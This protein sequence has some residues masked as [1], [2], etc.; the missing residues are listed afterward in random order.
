MNKFNFPSLQLKVLLCL[1]LSSHSLP[2]ALT[3]APVT[4][5]YASSLPKTLDSYTPGPK[6]LLH[7]LASSS[8]SAFFS[9]HHCSPLNL[10]SSF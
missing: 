4:T 7:S 6:H 3:K 2:R 1:P 9:H 10:F 8:L 5:L